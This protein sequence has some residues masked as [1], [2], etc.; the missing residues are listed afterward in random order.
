M[1]MVIVS[2][3]IGGT[4]EKAVTQ[5]SEVVSSFRTIFFR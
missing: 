4:G 2:E 5:V 3:I 1:Y